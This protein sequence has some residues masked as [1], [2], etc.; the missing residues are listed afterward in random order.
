MTRSSNTRIE[1]YG[2]GG[3]MR[4]TS[5]RCSVCGVSVGDTSKHIAWHKSKGG[6]VPN[7]VDGAI[8][9]TSAQA[10]QAAL[11]ARARLLLTRPSKAQRTA[12]LQRRARTI[13]GADDWKVYFRGRRALIQ[14]RN[15]LSTLGF[16]LTGDPDAFRSA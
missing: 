10:R 14:K 3:A 12:E 5:V 8:V 16:D 15:A 11:R 4:S 2:H 7:L 9:S 13:S 6:P 1:D